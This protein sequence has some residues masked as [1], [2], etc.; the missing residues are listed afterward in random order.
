[1]RPENECVINVSKPRGRF[2]DVDPNEISSNYSTCMLPNT[3]DNGEPITSPS[4][5]RYISDPIPKLLVFT[6]KFKHFH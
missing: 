4:S 6:Q 2:R 1:M 5:C 3:V